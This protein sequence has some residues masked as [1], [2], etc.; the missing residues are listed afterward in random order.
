MTV[1]M[2]VTMTVTMTTLLVRK[3]GRVREV[4]DNDSDNADFVGEEGR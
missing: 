3:V 1:P 2:V 4:G